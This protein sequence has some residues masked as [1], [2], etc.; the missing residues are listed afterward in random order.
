[1]T[2]KL[3]DFNGL[4][5]ERGLSGKALELLALTGVVRLPSALSGTMNAQVLLRG[6]A[7]PLV[8]PAVIAALFF[9]SHVLPSGLVLMTT[10]LQNLLREFLL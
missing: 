1:M 5:V 2:K 4:C 7:Y 6:A 10:L 9:F 8:V 3:N